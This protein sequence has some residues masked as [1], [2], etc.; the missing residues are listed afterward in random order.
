MAIGLQT[1]INVIGA[2][3]VA[4]SWAFLAAKKQ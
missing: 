3:P 1:E 4:L 2:I